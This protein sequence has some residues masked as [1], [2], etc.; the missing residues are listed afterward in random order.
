MSLENHTSEDSI[1][2]TITS[3]EKE[4]KIV[5]NTKNNIEQVIKLDDDEKIIE[6]DNDEGIFH[7]TVLSA[8][9]LEKAFEDLKRERKEREG[10]G[11][12]II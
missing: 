8:D 12:K 9:E 2:N 5:N 1:E 11:N 6:L 7:Y 3:V 10:E 4:G